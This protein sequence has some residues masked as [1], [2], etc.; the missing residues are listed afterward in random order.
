MKS[1]VITGATSMLGIAL[2]NQCIEHQLDVIAVV[3]PNSSKLNRIPKCKKIKIIECDINNYKNL[4]NLINCPVDTFYHIS[5]SVTNYNRNNDIYE[6]YCNIIYTLDAIN[7]ANDLG[8]ES[9][10]GTGSQSEYGLVSDDIEMINEDVIC[11]PNTPYGICKYSAGKLSMIQCEKFDIKCIWVRIFS[12]YGIYDKESTMITSSLLKIIRRERTQFT[13]GFQ[14]WDFLY[15][16]DAGRGLFLIGKH[17]KDK[18][19]YCLAN[20]SSKPLYEYIKIIERIVNPFYEMGIGLIPYTSNTVMNIS[21]D[22]SKLQSDTGFK[23]SYSFEEGILKTYNFLVQTE[24]N[25]Q[26]E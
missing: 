22:I 12:V 10:I 26:V 4:P 13:R 20:G 17:G 23:P 18:N 24:S 15:S 8:C 1:V 25:N 7:A 9:F 16:E 2:I 11:N 6:Q 5:W 3:R 21:A 19:V 14:L